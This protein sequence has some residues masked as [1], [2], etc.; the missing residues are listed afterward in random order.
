MELARMP[1]APALCCS[2]SMPGSNHPDAT[3]PLRGECQQSNRPKE[4]RPPMF[5]SECAREVLSKA[6]KR[7]NPALGAEYYSNFEVK[8]LILSK[9]CAQGW[10]KTRFSLI[11]L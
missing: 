6:Q 1:E 9:V 2:Q 11:T 10:V 7:K 4:L 5:F 8:L 3:P